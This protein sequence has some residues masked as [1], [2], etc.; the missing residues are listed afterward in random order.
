MILLIIP[1]RT[2]QFRFILD[3]VIY[4]LDELL[5]SPSLNCMQNIDIVQHTV[6]LIHQVA[7]FIDK[8]FV[9]TGCSDSLD[10]MMI[11]VVHMRVLQQQT[12]MIV[13]LV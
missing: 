9:Y 10:I 11:T 5:F 6:I 1:A 3:I 4:N 2:R 8:M 13:T 12:S 7:V